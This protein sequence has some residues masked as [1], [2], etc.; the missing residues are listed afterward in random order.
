MKNDLDF[1]K[2]IY[3]G[4]LIGVLNFNNMVPV[5]HL[6]VY[7]INLK[8]NPKDTS[9]ERHYKELM[10]DQLTYCQQNQEA[11]IKK[12]NKLYSMI[13]SGKANGLLKKRCCDFIKLEEI[14]KKKFQV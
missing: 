8:F 1:S 11:I 7:P 6:V 4:R 3:R 2:I 13:A 12:A 9:E 10:I 5:N 14:L